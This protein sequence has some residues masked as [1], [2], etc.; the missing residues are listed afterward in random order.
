[1]KSAKNKKNKPVQTSD[2]MFVDDHPLV[3][4]GLHQ[5]FET[6]ASFNICGEA[7]SMTEA[8]KK[9]KQHAPDMV[10]I[11][12]S[13]PDGSGLDLIKRVQI[14][15]P[16]ILILVYSMHD[17]DMFAE[18]AI[19]A[20]AKGYINKQEAGEN[21]I[22]AAKHILNGEIYLSPKIIERL[23]QVSN[24]SGN[25]AVISPAEQLS[26]RELEVFELIGHGKM[27]SEIA[28]LLRLS[29]KTIETHR[30]NI[31]AKLGLTSSG[32][33]TRSAIEWTLN[34]F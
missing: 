4:T 6:E 19:R 2:I 26:N 11:D 16:D 12:I 10:I 31:K 32:E 25:N 23:G 22:I 30:A 15:N 28:K 33:L 27:T 1:M 20:G 9:I 7:A 29:V 5:L 34:A 17:E 18:R 24:S 3:R 13:L 8:L 21:V 14:I